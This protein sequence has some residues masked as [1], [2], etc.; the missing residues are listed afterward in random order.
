[1][2]TI[3]LRVSDVALDKFLGLLSQFNAREI[4][5]VDKTGEFD[6]QRK[7]LH[8]QAERL[9]KGEAITYTIEQADALLEKNIR[10]Y[11]G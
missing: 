1:M 9:A 5:V 7:M 10:K 8:K 3:T 2:T 4:D 6:L 11:E